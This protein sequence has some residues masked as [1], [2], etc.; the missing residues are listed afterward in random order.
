[1]C[2]VLRLLHNRTF[3]RGSIFPGRE[4]RVILLTGTVKQSAQC[5]WGAMNVG[6]HIRYIGDN[7]VRREKTAIP[8]PGGRPL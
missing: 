7:L 4:N 6:E 3:L 8:Y 1:M 5:V 2:Q